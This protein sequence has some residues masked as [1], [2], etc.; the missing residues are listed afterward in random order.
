ME[1]TSA[2]IDDV[3]E[4]CILLNSLFTQEAEFNPDTETQTFAL[5]SIINNPETGDILV[6][7]KSGKI[8]AMINILY[9]VSTALGGRVAI[10]EDMVVLSKSRGQG[11]GSKL[12]TY[13]INFTKNKKCKRISLLTDMDNTD[14]HRFYQKHGFSNSSMLTLRLPLND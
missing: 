6:A 4:L 7:R 3:T 13:A 1:I 10:F 5:K 14:A 2:V 12:L 9:T 8:I 11:T